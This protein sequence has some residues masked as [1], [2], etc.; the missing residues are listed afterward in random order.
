[1][2]TVATP[3]EPPTTDLPFRDPALPLAQRVDDLIS[4]L[5]LDERIEL[6]Y[7]YSPGV[8]RLGLAPYKTGT[9]GLHGVA[10][11]GPATVFPQAI[12]LGATWDEELLHEVATAVGTEARAFHQRPAVDGHRHSLQI[13]APVVNLLRDPRW[14]RNEEGYAEGSRRPG[15][16]AP[17]RCPAAS[18]TTSSAP[19]GRTSTTTPHR[20]TPSGT[21]CPTP[22]SPTPTCGCPPGKRRR[23]TP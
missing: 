14:G 16:A 8:P 11:L 13:W 4:R 20:C 5:T 6:L 12:G 15:T 23:T 9:E 19:A 3:P 22:A 1:M 21:A 2:S 17:T 7:Q 10:W 18:T